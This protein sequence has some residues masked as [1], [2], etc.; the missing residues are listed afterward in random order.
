MKGIQ[1]EQIRQWRG[2]GEQAN[3]P[4]GAASLFD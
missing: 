4:E 1:P 2:A 3:A